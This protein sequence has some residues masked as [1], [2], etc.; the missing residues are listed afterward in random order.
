MTIWDVA[1]RMG[2]L[3]KDIH[4]QIRELQ[5]RQDDIRYNRRNY[6][7]WELSVN[8]IDLIIDKLYKQKKVAKI[9]EN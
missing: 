7:N 5:K 4:K 2:T 1:D 8:R 9:L 3:E 6:Y